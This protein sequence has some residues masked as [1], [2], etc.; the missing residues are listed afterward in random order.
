MWPIQDSYKTKLT[1][2]VGA[3][4]C[5]S[6]STWWLPTAD[7]FDR[8]MIVVQEEKE[9]EAVKETSVKENRLESTTKGIKNILLVELIL[10]SLLQISSLQ[11]FSSSAIIKNEWLIG[12]EMKWLRKGS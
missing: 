4:G 2:M 11:Q 3:A 8:L 9:E 6:S 1:G 5:I 10:E 7:G 12:W